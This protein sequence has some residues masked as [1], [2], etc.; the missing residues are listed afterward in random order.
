MQLR[1]PN[2]ECRYSLRPSAFCLLHSALLRAF[3]VRR[4]L[5]CVDQGPLPIDAPAISGQP[6]VLLHDTVAGHH[7]TD[8]VGRTRP[9]DRTN[10]AGCSN[11]AGDLAVGARFAEGDGLQISPDLPLKRRGLNVDREIEV[12]STPTEVGEDRFDPAAQVAPIR[13]DRR[14]WIFTPQIL[15]Q[16][17]VVSPSFTEQM[18]R[19]VAATRRRPS[20]ESATAYR[21]STPSAPRL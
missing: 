8:G 14:R 16:P 7:Q 17:L 13:R 2:A 6:A 9:R 18:P 19:D 11:G 12:R 3:L 20:G 1:R 4:L 15:G 5:F 21:T 10:C